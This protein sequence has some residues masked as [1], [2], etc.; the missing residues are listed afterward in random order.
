MVFICA[1]TVL[2][3]CSHD[4]FKN[5]IKENIE[6]T[7]DKE[8]ESSGWVDDSQ[9]CYRVAIK[10]T[11][12]IAGEYSHVQ[13]YFFIEEDTIIC[14]K[15]DYPSKLD[16]INNDRYVYDA[17]D[18]SADFADITFDGKEDIVISL[19]HQ[20]ASGTKVH[21][22]YIFEDNDY[23]YAKSFENIPNYY[24]NEESKC[25]NGEYEGEI[26]SYVYENGIF[27]QK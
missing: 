13:D 7:S 18:F 2:Q 23:I 14:I 4:N 8:I 26:F 27:K 3:G 9:K 17:C 16:N 15:V 1:I 19:G 6:L 21:C 22:A 10:R 5:A 11:S 25:V 24:I 20:G 12:D